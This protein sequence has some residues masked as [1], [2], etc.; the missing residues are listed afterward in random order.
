MEDFF[1]L[2]RPPLRSNTDNFV[3][4]VFQ[5]TSRQ[6]K[7]RQV[8]RNESAPPLLSSS[9]GCIGIGAVLFKAAMELKST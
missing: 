5:I 8:F 2:G 7:S 3:G 1:A 9:G 4:E 6:V